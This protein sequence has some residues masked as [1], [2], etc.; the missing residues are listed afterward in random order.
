MVIMRPLALPAV[1]TVFMRVPVMV[2]MLFMVVMRFMVSGF[3]MIVLLIHFASFYFIIRY[4][5]ALIFGLLFFVLHRQAQRYP[6]VHA[7]HG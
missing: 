1:V 5:P 4:F 6:I 2:F 3:L 7:A